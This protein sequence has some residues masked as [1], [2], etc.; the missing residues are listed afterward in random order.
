M[1][2]F[3]SSRSLDSGLSF[4][5]Q[6]TSLN[7]IFEDFSSAY[8]RFSVHCGTNSDRKLLIYRCQRTMF[9]VHYCGGVGDRVR[10]IISGFYAA[11]MTGRCFGIDWESVSD[12]ALFYEIPVSSFRGVQGRSEYTVV[13]ELGGESALLREID[14]RR[15]MELWRDREIVYYM[16]NEISWEKITQMPEFASSEF[17]SLAALNSYDQAHLVMRFLFSLKTQFFLHEFKDAI[18]QF[19]EDDVAIGVQMRLSE[20]RYTT[21]RDILVDHC[22]VPEMARQCLNFKESAKKSSC[23]YF[24]TADLPESEVVALLA[25]LKKKLDDTFKT[26]SPNDIVSYKLVSSPISSTHIDHFNLLYSLLGIWNIRD[27]LGTFL[28]WELLKSVDVLLMSRSGFPQSAYWY[29]G[30]PALVL[31]TFGNECKFLPAT[32][33]SAFSINSTA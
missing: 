31:N 23:F 28:D 22:F 3:C 33:D 12:I 25:E 24:V 17:S 26:L 6:T 21:D 29:S 20:G 10:G 13:P 32:K 16:S 19:C 1:K 2:R 8:H 11:M 5:H 27:Y 9:G 14:G 30:M 7:A 15:E 18:S 4:P